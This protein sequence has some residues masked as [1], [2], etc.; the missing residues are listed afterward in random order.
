M[1]EV[2]GRKYFTIKLISF[3]VT[4]VEVTIINL[5]ETVSARSLKLICNQ[6]PNDL[7]FDYIMALSA[8][9]GFVMLQIY[10]VFTFYTIVM[11]QCSATYLLVKL[12][13]SSCV[14]GW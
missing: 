2:K 11:Y 14:M 13:E 6:H 12:I 8:L 9:Y 3:T 10:I 7:D 5:W 1:K 4:C